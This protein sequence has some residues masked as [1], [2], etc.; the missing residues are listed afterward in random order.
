MQT[1]IV[2][3]IFL[4]SSLIIASL[5][6]MQTPI[7]NLTLRALCMRK[8]QTL[9]PAIIQ[10]AIPCLPDECW[11]PMVKSAL[12]L[13]IYPLIIDKQAKTLSGHTGAVCS[14]ATMENGTIVSGSG[15][16]T[17]KIWDIKNLFIHTLS[18]ERLKKAFATFCV[19][20]ES[21]EKWLEWH[22]KEDASEALK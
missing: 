1:N 4:C 16:N 15:D 19:N 22:Q 8:A 10:K 2:T 9:P 14:V 5:L 6:P 7:N 13:K 11:Q 21:S 17:I 3:I 12:A 18:N 20:K